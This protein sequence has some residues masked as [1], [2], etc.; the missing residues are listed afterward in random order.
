MNLYVE[1]MLV[2]FLEI[3]LNEILFFA[4]REREQFK[5]SNKTIFS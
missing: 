1:R 4:L 2:A 3:Y 5:K